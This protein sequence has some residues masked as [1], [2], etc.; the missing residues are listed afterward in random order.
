MRL[1]AMKVPGSA[2]RCDFHDIPSGTY[3]LVVLHDENMNGKVDTN[4][5]GVP[6][7]GYRF[8]KDAKASFSAPSFKDAGFVYDGKTLV[9]TIRLHY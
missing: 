9:M 7:E 1:V 3:A 6:K 2:A 8:S 4:W 5:I